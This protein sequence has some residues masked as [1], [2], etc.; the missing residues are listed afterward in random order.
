MQAAGGTPAFDSGPLSPGGNFVVTFGAEGVYTYHCQ[1]HPMQGTINVVAGAQGLATVTIENSPDVQFNP[2]IVSVAPGGQVRWNYTAAPG[3]G[4]PV[5]T[6]TEDAAGMPSYCFN[7]RSFVGNTPTIVAE[8][9]QRIRWYIFDLDL[10]MAWHNFHPHASRWQF[11]DQIVDARSIGPA[12]SFIVET[13][14]PPVLILPGDIERTQDPRRRPKNAKPYRLRGDFLFH[15]HVEMHMMGGM[16]GLIR[17]LQTVWLTNKQADE[18]RATMGLPVDDGQNTCP[19][20]DADRCAAAGC[21]RWDPVPGVPQVTMMHA[22]LIPNTDKILFWGYGD[23]RT[24]IS[25]IWDYSGGGVY[26]VPPNQ[27]ADVERVAG[28]IGLQNIW[29]AEHAYDAQGTLLAHGGFTPRESYLF[30]PATSQWALTAATAEDRFYSTTLTLADGRILTL[31]G[32]S[33]VSIEVYDPA[34]GTWAPPIALPFSDYQ[35]YPW[36]YLLP[37]GDL[38]IAGPEGVGRRIRL[39]CRAHPN[40]VVVDE[41]RQPRHIEGPEGHIGAP[42]VAPAWL[43]AARA[44]RRGRHVGNPVVGGV[45]RPVGADARLVEPPEPQSATA[46]ASEY[47]SLA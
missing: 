40:P 8:A 18:L 6:V 21:G 39:D 26:S 13:I 25:R 16:V 10:S 31:F 4:V 47:R 45:D 30:D 44:H 36:T 34:A 15:C 19:D 32:S 11:A 5:H 22:A 1:F 20:I 3:P 7:G 23:T 46:A 42:P 35:F 33:S 17:S 27:P 41:R 2:A 37:G 14:T 9:G 29:S 12:E 24:D 28:D 38:F 43:R